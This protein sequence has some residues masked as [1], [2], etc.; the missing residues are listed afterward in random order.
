MQH[1]RKRHIHPLLL[2]Y[3]KYWPVVGLLGLRKSGKSTLFRESLQLDN[4]I[5]L[6]DTDIQDEA[7]KSP[8]IFLQKLSRPLV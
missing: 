8:K 1:Q 5:T 3:G 4:Y 2:Q 7:K 6:D